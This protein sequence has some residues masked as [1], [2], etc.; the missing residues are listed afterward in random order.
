MRWWKPEYFSDLKEFDILTLDQVA[1][2][3]LN[4]LLTFDDF[5]DQYSRGFSFMYI[6]K[7]D[8][9]YDEIK[10]LHEK[11]NPKNYKGENY[12]LIYVDKEH[13]QF[14]KE[15]YCNKLGGGNTSNYNNRDG[16]LRGGF[17][18]P[19]PLFYYY[20]PKLRGIITGEY[21]Y[22]KFPWQLIYYHLYETNNN[23]SQNVAKFFVDEVNNTIG[24]DDVEEIRTV[25]EKYDKNYPGWNHDFPVSGFRQYVKDGLLFPG[26]WFSPGVLAQHSHHRLA[27]TAF[28]KEDFPFIIPIR[29]TPQWEVVTPHYNYIYKFKLCKLVLKV[30]MEQ[31]TAD[32]YFRDKENNDIK[33]VID[34]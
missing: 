14:Y 7:E 12:K 26:F 19:R 27:M 11:F 16:Q 2:R 24:W 18:T 3:Y 1:I 28:N 23:I 22:L 34:E 21:I 10:R 17:A 9:A 33:F 8:L 13:R 20:F 5:V 6:P 31:R 30:D 4:C 25:V 15:E 29:A 32:F